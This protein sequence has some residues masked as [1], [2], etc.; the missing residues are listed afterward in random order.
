[1]KALD[2]ALRNLE[3]E[4]KETRNDITKFVGQ[5]TLNEVHQQLDAYKK[6]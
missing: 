6:Y 4:I 2:R 3:H 1:M 5:N